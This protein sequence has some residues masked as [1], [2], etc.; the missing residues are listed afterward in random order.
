[1]GIKDY[2]GGVIRPTPVVPQGPFQDGAAPGVWTL[3]R[4]ADYIKQ[5]IWPTA[6]NVAPIGLFGGGK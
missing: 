4:V 2:P 3:D 5:G 6:G 1:M